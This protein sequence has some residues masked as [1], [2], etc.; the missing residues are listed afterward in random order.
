MFIY[1]SHF[2]NDSLPKN[3]LQPI[4]EDSTMT[5]AEYL[6][7]V[8]HRFA[9]ISFVFYSVEYGNPPKVNR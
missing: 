4:H 3:A 8:R 1:E 9:N 5:M 7:D 2:A 6:G